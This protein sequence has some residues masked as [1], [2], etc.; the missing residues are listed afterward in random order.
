MIRRALIVLAYLFVRLILWL[1]IPLLRMLGR[2]LGDLV[3]LADGRRRRIVET[4][5]ALCFAQM[6]P[7]QRQRLA[8]DNLRST[9]ESLIEYL[10]AWWMPRWRTRSLARIEGLEHLDVALAAGRGVL[11]MGAHM[12]CAEIALRLLGENSAAQITLLARRHNDPAIARWVDQGRAR[13]IGQTLEKKDVQGLLR[14]LRAGRVVG[15]AADQDFNYQSAFLPFF[16]VP[17]ATLTAWSKLLKRTGAAVLFMHTARLAG[18]RYLLRIET[19]DA[20]IPSADP[21]ADTRH[22]LALVE[23][24]VREHPEQY[25]WAHRRFKTRPSGESAADYPPKP[26]RRR[27]TPISDKDRVRLPGD[28]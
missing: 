7:A 11:L 12:H 23:A 27:D 22:Y 14:A 1:P 28:S 24:Q 3:W 15:Y 10:M 19:M 25:L 21:V 18:G 2:R 8:R 9:G 4:N 13:R 17:A 20:S 5:L 26:A 16:G 6:P